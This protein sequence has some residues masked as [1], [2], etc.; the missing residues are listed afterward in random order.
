MSEALKSINQADI[1]CETAL[2]LPKASLRLPLASVMLGVGLEVE[3]IQQRE[4][5]WVL[6][7]LE[8]KGPRIRTVAV[9]IWVK[10]GIDHLRRCV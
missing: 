3:T 5:R 4:G 7:D 10:K 9:P 8:G 2:R 6:A 1:A